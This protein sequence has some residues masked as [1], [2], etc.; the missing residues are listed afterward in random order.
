[1]KKTLSILL[2]MVM[3]LSVTAGLSFN[4]FA[5]SYIDEVELYHIDIP[6][7]GQSPNFM[8]TQYDFDGAYAS[9]LTECKINSAPYQE[10]IAWFDIT[11]NSYINPADTSYKFKCG[12]GYQVFVMVE[13]K[14]TQGGQIMF[15]DPSQMWARVTFGSLSDG[16]EGQNTAVLSNP[17]AMAGEEDYSRVICSEFYV[18]HSFNDNYEVSW[19]VNNNCTCTGVCL[20]CSKI[21]TETVA[22]VKSVKTAPTC[23]EDGEALYTATF[24]K[25]FDTET[26]TGPIEALK[27]DFGTGINAEYEV[28]W[29]ENNNCTCTGKCKRC[30][31]TIT[32]KGTVDTDVNK[33]PTCTKWG[34]TKYTAHF[35]L[36]FDDEFEIL[37]D[38]EPLGHDFSGGAKA[39]KNCGKK[40]NTLKVKAKTVK[41]K[42]A[43][44]KKKNVT[45]ARKNA[46]T[47]SKAKGKVT[48]QK[49][50]GNKKIVINKKTGKI[51]VKK[52]L[53]KGTYK[54]KVKVKAAGKGSYLSGYKTVTVKIV[55]K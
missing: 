34:E 39:C 40:K 23:T 54:V 43:T 53:K 11:D 9:D 2:S 33:A 17:K 6:V 8:A 52:G 21:V 51:T 26:T 47:V 32:E 38:I 31:K 46:L 22:G 45:I 50:K 49:V 16:I 12:H 44:V 42:K 7:A 3:L 24:T 41:V 5:E 28:E 37:E 25:G 36:G 20:N 13:I 30:G 35:L 15:A 29:D 1:M 27:H 4:A 55:V 14:D 18:P 10:G 19:D 48:Y